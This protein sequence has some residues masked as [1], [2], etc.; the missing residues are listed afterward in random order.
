MKKLLFLMLALS[1]SLA[2]VARAENDNKERKRHKRAAG[3]DF[4]PARYENAKD[5]GCP[6]SYACKE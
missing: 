4:S 3:D 1:I 6:A 2:Q 5:H